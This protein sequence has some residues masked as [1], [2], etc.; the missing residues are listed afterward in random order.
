MA[1]TAFGWSLAV[2]SGPFKNYSLYYITSDHGR[3]FGRT[4]GVTQAAFGPI[5]CTGP[6]N[7]KNAEWPALTTNGRPGPAA[8]A[9]SSR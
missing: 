5:T 8:V 7:D 3:S 2:G 1:D 9:C 4:T 6:S